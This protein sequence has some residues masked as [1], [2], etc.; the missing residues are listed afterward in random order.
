MTIP[1]PI[2]QK[3]RSLGSRISRAVTRSMLALLRRFIALNYVAGAPTRLAS[4]GPTDAPHGSIEGRNR[5]HILVVG[6]LSG[7]AVGVTSYGFGVTALLA[8]SLARE[9]GRGVDW[10]SLS[11]ENTKL[12]GTAATLRAMDGLAS[13]DVILISTGSADALAFTSF[14][15]WRAELTSLLAFLDHSV[16]PSALVAVTG[17]PDVSPHVQAGRLVS[18]TLALDC[19]EFNAIVAESCRALPRVQRVA[20]PAAEASDFIDGAFSYSTLYRR[21]AAW[22]CEF[23]MARLSAV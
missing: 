5:L 8:R 10:E 1:A 21:W 2:W 9:T 11:Q 13:F 17:V 19:R 15:A 16:S 23:V 18:R 14:R 4:G 6:G 20:M 3:S 22:L 7:S 12:A